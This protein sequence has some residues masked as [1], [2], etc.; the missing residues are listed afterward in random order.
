MASDQWEQLQ[1]I[2]LE[3]TA[4]PASERPEFLDEACGDNAELR[5][6]VEKLLAEDDE[7]GSSEILKPVDFDFQDLYS[8]TA[9]PDPN[10]G[11]MIGPYEIRRRLGAGGMGSVYLA[12]RTGEFRQTVAIKL[13]KRGMDTEEILRRFRHERQVLAGLNHPNIAKFINGGTTDDGLPYFVMEYVEGEP[14]DVYCDKH[15]LNTIE[16]LKL[17]QEVCGA[18]HAAHQNTVI[19]RDLK[20]SNILVTANGQPKL[21]D[22]GIAKLT[23]RELGFQTLDY[24]RTEYRFMTPEYASPEQVRGDMI[25]TAS[26]VYSLGVVLY[27]L[28]TG[29]R[30]YELTSR[31]KR[32]IEEVICGDTEP[33]KP[34]EVISRQVEVRRGATTITITPEAVS[35]TRE[36]DPQRLRRRLRGDV[37]N[38]VLMALRKEPRHRYQSS[39][40]LAADVQRYLAGEPVLAVPPTL[41]YRVNKFIRK[42]RGAA[43]A[44]L[45]FVVLLAAFG[46]VASVQAKRH[47]DLA[48]SE[49]FAKESERRA[50]EVAEAKSAEAEAQRELAARAEAEALLEAYIANLAGASVCLEALNYAG[51]LRRLQACDPK[52]RRWEWYHLWRRSEP[53]LALLQAGSAKDSSGHY[54]DAWFSQDGKRVFCQSRESLDTYD[55]QTHDLEKGISHH[56]A[57]GD[58]R[59]VVLASPDGE[60]V[61][62][63][64]WNG[65][66]REYLAVEAETGKV[67][68]RLQPC[69]GIGGPRFISSPDGRWIAAIPTSRDNVTLPVWCAET[70]ELVAQLGGV[71]YGCPRE[72]AFSSD[73]DKLAVASTVFSKHPDPLRGTHDVYW[74]EES[75]LVVWSVDRR[76]DPQVVDTSSHSEVDG[77][78]THFSGLY[79]LLFACNDRYLITCQRSMVGNR[80]VG[81]L[82]IWD[83]SKKSVV[84]RIECDSAGAVAVRPDGRE[85]AITARGRTIRLLSV[86]TGREVGSICGWGESLR[87]SPN[88]TELVSTHRGEAIRIWGTRANG[89]SLEWDGQVEAVSADARYVYSRPRGICEVASGRYVP[90]Q[91]YLDCDSAAF[92]PDGRYLAIGDKRG[93]IH[94]CDVGTG[95]HLKS[96]Q[97]HHNNSIR[98][99]WLPDSRRLASAAAEVAVKS[100]T[101]EA[102]DLTAFEDHSVRIWDVQTND[103]PVVLHGTDGAVSALVCSPD[104]Q[105][106]AAA[107]TSRSFWGLDSDHQITPAVY[108]WD[109]GSA[110]LRAVWELSRDRPFSK[111][112]EIILTKILGLAFHPEGRVLAG[113]GDDFTLRVWRAR[114]MQ[115][116]SSVKNDWGLG[117]LVFH[118]DGSRIVS[119][120]DETIQVWDSESLK[121]LAGIDQPA[122]A[123]AFTPDG[124]DLV[125]EVA[126]GDA[127]G[128]L[129][130][131][132]TVLM[133]G[134]SGRDSIIGESTFPVRAGVI[135]KSDTTPGNLRA[136]YKTVDHLWPGPKQ[137]SPDHDP[138]GESVRSVGEAAEE[139]RAALEQRYKGQGA[140]VFRVNPEGLEACSVYCGLLV[141]RS[142]AVPPYPGGVFRVRPGHPEVVFHQPAEECELHVSASGHHQFRRPINL[143]SG[144][145]IVLDDVALTPILADTSARISGLVEIKGSGVA[146]S[147]IV[148]LSFG[149]GQIPIQSTIADASGRFSMSHAPSGLFRI[150]ARKQGY[151][152]TSVPV[153]HEKRDEIETVVQGYPLLGARVRWAYRSGASWNFA[154]PAVLAG[155]RVLCSQSGGASPRSYACRGGFQPVPWH[156]NYHYGS[157]D[158]FLYQAEDNLLLGTES[159]TLMCRKVDETSDDYA[160]SLL[161]PASGLRLDEGASYLF[162][163]RDGEHH[164]KMEVLKILEGAAEIREAILDVMVTETASSDASE[165][166][167]PRP[168]RA[169]GVS[170][171]R[172]TGGELILE[173]EQ[174]RQRSNGG[175]QRPTLPA[176][177]PPSTKPMTTSPAVSRPSL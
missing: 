25:T 73:G 145:V 91:T 78:F 146:D 67:L 124:R 169:E 153:E 81:T 16:R 142:E 135:E 3:A 64:T 99:Q 164:A 162:K 110:Q 136:S 101:P 45:A 156:L 111:P 10:I 38:I 94:L 152:F 138:A 158:F 174:G 12:A 89:Y 113:V 97:T 104:G 11:R 54:T 107:T 49:R 92:S 96:I 114:D 131:S 40:Q 13:I 144:Q 36:G 150:T 6:E 122:D 149:P 17:F 117:P 165:Q 9:S 109:L 58:L 48:K 44:G 175:R 1:Q 72:A 160:A 50:R 125:V 177:H 22:F 159:G 43:A 102:G 157:A 106:L 141:K 59:E 7:A 30:P 69:P 121:T 112:G 47:A 32:E 139:A 23:N 57:D 168:G 119:A 103:A 83:V 28:L 129:G 173:T 80:A 108:A 76:A 66:Q 88:G 71:E 26:D 118:P 8:H 166:S 86:P 127:T 134:F 116:V 62:I 42:N 115:L 147:A 98:L 154:E 53:S 4:L 21:V 151:R 27:E 74:G 56:G 37:D 84:E 18:V 19:H 90:T 155:E 24:T 105:S 148:T 55:L 15:K 128:G 60:R 130:R 133:S 123:V 52:L 34:S 29:H 163:C 33:P 63:L 170:D 79:A 5:A 161:A 172:P 70:G 95:S 126:Q 31:L 14:I 65:G 171:G 100:V 51:A 176:S 61:L 39:E 87:Y 93:R 20:P 137:G 140:L 35:K 41:Q 85:L 167:S 68:V 2:F 75:H 77:H 120:T 132:M 143:R 46:A 82:W